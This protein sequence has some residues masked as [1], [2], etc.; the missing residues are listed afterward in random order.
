MKPGPDRQAALAQYRARAA[1]YDLELMIFEP[2]RRSAVALLDLQRGQTVIDVACGTGLSFPL[3]MS[4]V[5]PRGRVLGIEQ[6]P[7]MAARA[8]ARIQ[9]EGWRR[10]EL[11][12]SPVEAAEIGVRAH[13]ALFH[14][15]HDV[16]QQPDAVRNVMSALAPGARVVACGLKWAPAWLAATNLFVLPAALRSVTSLAG[17]QAPWMAL[18]PHV[19]DLTVSPLLAGGAYIASGR[20]PR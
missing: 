15:T 5:G 16:L 6:S 20:M 1:V 2:L 14:F 7:E 8:R 4:A 12:E 17:L 9:R 3:L 18:K 19:P 13:A 10:V 11:I